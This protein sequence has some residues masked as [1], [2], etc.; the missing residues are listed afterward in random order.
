MLA[1]GGQYQY[2]VLMACCILHLRQE[3]K[4]F[5]MLTLYRPIEHQIL[6]LPTIVNLFKCDN[7]D[8]LNMRLELTLGNLESFM[9]TDSV[10]Y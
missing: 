2:H 10:T 8:Y 4:L 7:C 9:M 6:S 1:F 5:P 3:A